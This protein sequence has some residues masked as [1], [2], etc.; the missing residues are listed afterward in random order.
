MAKPKKSRCIP[1]EIFPF[2]SFG[3]GGTAAGANWVADLLQEIVDDTAE[4][5]R[6]NRP[7]AYADLLEVNERQFDSLDDL[8]NWQS[9][10]S[11]AAK[12]LLS[13]DPP[14]FWF[15]GNHLGVM[16][17]YQQLADQFGDELL[18]IQFDA[19]LDCYDYHDTLPE[20]NH[21]NFLRHLDRSPRIVNVGHR[22]LFLTEQEVGDYFERTIAAER[23]AA[24]E[25]SAVKELRT[26]CRGSQ[27]VWLDIDLDVFDPVSFPAV[28]TRVPFG[29]SPFV[30]LRLLT[31]VWQPNCIGVSVSEF[32]PGRDE[33]DRSHETLAWLIEW[34]LSRA[35][36]FQVS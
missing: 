34:L 6:P 31:Q 26:L 4:E 9:I 33:N 2:D 28:P 24:D 17:I 35:V 14:G 23:I 25:A 13:V 27:R 12:E 10:G 16:P 29:L 36:A 22:D 30:L 11:E 8:T 20:L 21:G 15:A 1:V 32:A 19:H 5:T 18:V 3:G 7:S